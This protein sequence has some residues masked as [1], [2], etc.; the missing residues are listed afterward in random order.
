M[1]PIDIDKVP[2]RAKKIVVSIEPAEW[3]MYIAH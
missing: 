3:Q 2:S 1:M